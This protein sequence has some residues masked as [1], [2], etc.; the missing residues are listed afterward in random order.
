MENILS[1]F[2][3]SIYVLFTVSVLCLAVG[4]EKISA[5]Q[6]KMNVHSRSVF[7]QRSAVSLTPAILVMGLLCFLSVFVVPT[8][9]AA[10]LVDS[11][12]L[13]L[14]NGESRSS[15]FWWAGGAGSLRPG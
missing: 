15:S 10:A 13:P 11:S 3:I 1:E 4:S 7:E 12:L 14:T 8:A 9:A 5:E 6:E 2:C